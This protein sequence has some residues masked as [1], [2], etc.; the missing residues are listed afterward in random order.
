M[1][2]GAPPAGRLTLI[3]P[4]TGRELS[5]LQTWLAI[6]VMLSGTT[7]VALVVTAVSPIMHQLSDYFGKG[8]L[9]KEVAY[10]IAIVPS[11]GIMLGG[12]ITGLVIEKVGS[13]NFLLTILVIFGIV[14]SAGLYL[15]NVWVLIASRFILGVSAAGIVT[16]TL[17]MIG[18]YF[19][20]V[21]RA[22]ILG[23]QGAVGAVAALLII[24]SAGQLAE[25]AGWRAPFAMYLLAFVIFFAAAIAIP[26]RPLAEFRKVKE[27]APPGT[28]IAL[29]PVIAVIM[30]L[31]VGSFM[32]TLQVSFLLADNG[33]MSA[34]TSSLVL[35]ASALMVGI[36]SA[37]YGP[38]RLRLGDRWTLCLC[39]A[40]IGAGIVVMGLSRGAAGVALGCAISGAGTGLLN[41]QTNN[42]LI[43]RAGPG[44]R[45]RAVGMGYFARYAGDFLNPVIVGPLTAR[46]GIH[47]AF[48]LT[49]AAFIVGAMVELLSR[50]R[51][52]SVVSA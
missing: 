41:P 21:M 15:E 48:I 38:V 52:R 19:E 16:G 44:A 9:G 32:P 13:R 29:L 47:I 27:V 30:L 28:I 51:R 39:A 17:I 42:L 5:R 33:V 23:Y 37:L 6:I 7:F 31:F 36:G 49:G 24:L 20:P 22:R 18:E 43:T 10:G 35:G 11:I 12:P 4:A 1:S 8:G 2:P 3:D 26:K 25:W 46:F 50:L 14:G 34:S 40:L 45:G